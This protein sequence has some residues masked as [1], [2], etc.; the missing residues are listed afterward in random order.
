MSDPVADFIRAIL[1]GHIVL[2]RELASRGHFPAID[3][4]HSI[5]RVMPDIAEPPHLASARTLLEIL[6]TYRNAEDLINLGAYRSGS[7]PRLDIAV[8]MMDSLRSF[9]RQ[10]VSDRAD[11]ESSLHRLK[12]LTAQAQEMGKKFMGDRQ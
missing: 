12:Q 9:L 1:D 11:L 7:N 3:I 2:S 4:L 5:S 10:E 8:A 6:A